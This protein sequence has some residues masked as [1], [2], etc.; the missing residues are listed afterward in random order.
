MG[1]EREK[2]ARGRSSARRLG[3]IYKRLNKNYIAKEL[4]A[5]EI[6]QRIGPGFELAD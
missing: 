6:S 3:R 1:D 2:R 4:N 5:I